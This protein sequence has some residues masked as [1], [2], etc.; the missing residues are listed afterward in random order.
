M[1]YV[2]VNVYNSYFEKGGIVMRKVISSMV[3]MNVVRS[4]IFNATML[5]LIAMVSFAFNLAPVGI[6][7]LLLFFIVIV[8]KVIGAN[9]FINKAAREFNDDEMVKYYVVN[10]VLVF[11]HIIVDCTSNYNLIRVNDIERINFSDSVFERV[12]WGDKASKFITI[13]SDSSYIKIQ[14]D[15]ESQAQKYADFIYSNNPKIELYN[16]EFKKTT[17]F[18]DLFNLDSKT[19]Y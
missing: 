5:L 2:L 9:K 11:D 15:T 10:S 19:R 3:F 14:F 1:S 8:Y 17:K 13:T 16:I 18:N 4:F 6:V 12:K 7:A